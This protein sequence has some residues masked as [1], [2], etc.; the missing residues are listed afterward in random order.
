MAELDFGVLLGLAY[1]DMVAEL[2]DYL[3]ARGFTGLRPSFGFA[4]KALDRQSLTTSELAARLK[5]TPQ[6]AAKIV[7]EMAVAGYVQRAPDPADKRLK[8]L[9]LTDRCRSLLA[10][11]HDFHAGFEQRLREQ[12]G[13]GQVAAARQVLTAVLGR[14]GGEEPADSL[15]GLLRGTPAR[16]PLP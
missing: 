10:A 15:A 1:Q 13:P 3:A 2:H 5:I 8:R 7:D 11:A 16:P 4:F 9:T 12:A 14:A 6:G